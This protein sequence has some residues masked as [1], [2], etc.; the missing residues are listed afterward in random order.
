MHKKSL[1]SHIL[2]TR[3]N[4]PWVNG[5]SPDEEW[6]KDRIQLFLKYCLP[7]VYKQTNTNYKWI[8]YLDTNTPKWVIESLNASIQPNTHL[9]NVSTFDEM[10]KQVSNDVLNLCENNS[11]FV[12]TS[13]L[14]NDDIVSPYF[15]EQIQQNFISTHNS[16]I[17]FS[18]GICYHLQKNIFSTYTYPN[19]P[20]VSKIESV[21]EQI[22]T[23]L[24]HDHTFINAQIQITCKHWIQLIHQSNISNGLKGKIQLNNNLLKN[25]NW[26]AS[27]DLK[28]NAFNAIWWR[29]K[30]KK[31]EIILSIKKQIK[32]II[33]RA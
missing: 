9:I 25:N 23:I 33:R 13:R 16:F 20:F 30:Q 12:I 24:A 26:I 18:G 8:I 27:F 7:S 31:N 17:N 11:K 32:K 4:V 1:F 5:K 15:I 19:G 10:K 29:A 14:D 3:F 28:T 21:E 22:T 2:I 6:L